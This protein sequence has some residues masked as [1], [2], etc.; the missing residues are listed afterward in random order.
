M[1]SIQDNTKQ[2]MEF[3]NSCLYEDGAPRYAST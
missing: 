2:H 3:K 1:Y